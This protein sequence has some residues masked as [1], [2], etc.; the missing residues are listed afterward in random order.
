VTRPRGAF[1]R[2]L[3]APMILGAILNPVNSSII[4]V[5]LVPIGRAFGAPVSQTAWL[6]SALYLATAIGQPVVGRLVDAYGPRRLY[7]AGTALVG[8]AGVLG[9]LA[10]SLP[11]LVAARVLLGFGTCAGYPAAMYLI[12]SEARRTGE[13]SPAAVLTALAIATQTIAVI[14]PSLGGLL[15]GLGGWRATLAVNIPLSLAGVALGALRLPR[16]SLLDARADRIDVPGIGLFALTLTALL[17]FLMDIESGRLFLLLVV[18]AGAAAFAARELRAEQPFIDLRVLSGNVALLATYGRT[19]LTS[20]VSYSFLYGFT[21]WLEDGR[22]LSASGAGLVLLPMFGTGIAVAAL[23]GRRPEVRG[24]LLA[25]GAAQILAC[26]L[27]PLLAGGSPV[28]LLVVIAVILGVPQG[29]NSLANQNALY[30][31]ADPE[32]IGASAGLLRTFNYLGA[33]AAS[34]AAAAFFGSTAGT[35][36]LHHFAV[37]LLIVAA[38][39][40][41]LT[42]ADR[43][44]AR[45][46]RHSEPEEH[47]VTLT[48]IDP[49]P[50]LVVIDLQS[51]VVGMPTIHPTGAIVERSAE[52]ADAFR[53]RGLPVVLV[54]V[55]G[56]APGRTEQPPRVSGE[57]PE[58]FTTLV[59]ELGRHPDDILIT[60][61]TRGAFTNTGLEERLRE[62]G[63]TQ[64]VITGISTSGGVE[65]TARDAYERGFHVTLASDAL[66][67]IDPGAHEHSL[68]KV[69]PRIGETGTTEEIVALL[70][71]AE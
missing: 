59:P 17:V 39:F 13:D 33:I 4:A 38:L 10:P 7:L 57:L 14:G 32:R 71:Q 44:L 56:T 28:W 5:S 43:S 29:L 63:V 58:A 35:A 2:R 50:A 22:H 40:F 1:D 61:R 27:L 12:R 68:T 9:A 11:L 3:L 20:L 21:Q 51:G 24:K 36:G 41:A 66:T 18:A 16:G 69:F 55:A 46:G 60:K 45:I 37:F 34:A 64:V 53:A 15:I 49:K 19:L 70:P 30:H 67:D 54:N 47:P 6:V 31:Q 25:G 62:R 65:S 42:L 23:A 26:A 52:L 8:V 48:A